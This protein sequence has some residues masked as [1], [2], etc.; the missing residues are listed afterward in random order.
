MTE[1]GVSKKLTVVILSI[2]S[3]VGLASTAENKWPYA[4]VIG[5][6]CVIFWAVQGFMDW[7]NKHGEG[8]EEEGR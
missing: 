4:I 8:N 2:N 1:N 7:S 5:A 3:V 6:I